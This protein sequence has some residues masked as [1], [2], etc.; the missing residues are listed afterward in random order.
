MKLKNLL[1]EAK[2]T[3]IGFGKYKEKGKEKDP[4]AQTFQKDD[5][6]KFVPFKS[7]D[8]KSKK[9][10]SKVNIFNKPTTKG[11]PGSGRKPKEQPQSTSHTPINVD[12]SETRTIQ[13]YSN[14]R[15][16]A[17]TDFV[18][19][20]KLDATALAN[21]LQKG[22]LNDRM[23]FITA[24]V[25]EPGNKYEKKLI[26]KF[27]EKGG[28][29]EEPKSQQP[30][31]YNQRRKGNPKVNKEAYAAAEKFGI[32]PQKLGNE[33]YK[34]AM[35]QAAVEALTDAN[36]HDE[37][38]ELVASIEG[39]PEWAKKVN[40]PS[41]DD[42][43]YKEKMADIRKNGVDSSEYWD[44]EGEAH[45]LGRKVSQASGWGGVEAA[46][47]IA[48]TLRMNGFHKEADKI[49]SIFDNKAYMKS[50]NKESKISLKSL[51]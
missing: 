37:A 32:T 51:Y 33:E 29:T 16:Q 50:M 23:D 28:K 22:S 49:Q 42:P 46:D 6:G 38:R 47:G 34:K 5:A 17:I 4:K 2:Y 39:K 10:S 11:G 3:Y 48:F 15:P 36:F 44:S 9:S 26:D 19:K 20:H 35:Y 31:I 12:S 7:D 25:G 8:T 1:I 30:A 13:T 41:M 45:E 18:N 40:Y 21:F 24:L 27:G 43:K 14:A